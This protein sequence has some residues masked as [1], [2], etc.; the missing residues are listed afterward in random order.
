MHLIGKGGLAMKLV[1]LKSPWD[2]THQLPS[3]WS[4]GFTALETRGWSLR[5]TVT[6][7]LRNVTQEDDQY[8]SWH[9]SPSGV[10][11]R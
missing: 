6:S 7:S 5:A 11:S 10:V 1:A 8:V 9:D 2:P 3:G 4:S